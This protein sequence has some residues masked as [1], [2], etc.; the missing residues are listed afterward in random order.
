MGRLRR[1][2]DVEKGSSVAVLGLQLVKAVTQWN[3]CGLWLSSRTGVPS[4]RP[5]SNLKPQKWE[6]GKVR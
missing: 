5:D 6:R 4:L 3:G 2:Q 1:N